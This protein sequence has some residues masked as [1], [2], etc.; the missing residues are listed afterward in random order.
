MI[1]LGFFG[2]CCLSALFLCLVF[3]ARLGIWHWQKT[4]E[5]L[6]LVS[7]KK[8]IQTKELTDHGAFLLQKSKTKVI[9]CSHT[10]SSFKLLG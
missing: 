4:L 5:A 8:V 10:Q 6:S 3:D 7:T 9:Y 2:M 1:R